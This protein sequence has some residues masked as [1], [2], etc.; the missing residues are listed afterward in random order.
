[1]TER[2]SATQL[3]SEFPLE[4]GLAYLNHAAVAPWPRR[5]SDAVA[6]FA[7]ENSHLGATHYPQWLTVEDQLRHNLA[8]LINAPSAQDI[9]LCKNTSEALSMVAAGLD[10]HEGDEIII[11]SQEFPSNRIVWESLVSRGVRIRV[12]DID[13]Q[14]VTPEGAIEDLITD[15][16]RLMSVSSVQYG[17][18]LRLDAAHLGALCDSHGILF[19]LD[20]IQS[21]GAEP[22]DVQAAGAHFAMADGHKWMLGPEGLAF[23]YVAPEWRESLK[24]YEYGWHMVAD[25][26]NFDRKDW[27]PAPDARRF[28]CGSPNLLAAHALEASTGLLLEVGLDQVRSLIDQRVSR[29]ASGLD[30]IKGIT[31]VTP[32]EP[33]RRLGIYTVQVDG[34]DNRHL[35]DRLAQQRVISASRGGGVRFSPHFYT[36]Y[37]AL[38]QALDT[39]ER[40]VRQG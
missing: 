36:P 33:Q 30:R 38:E 13:R 5:A 16:T 35:C 7:H 23:F 31:P 28:E 2:F 37:A 15:R 3:L 18:G 20:A 29:L 4:A 10:W 25:P 26:G 24:L 27:A 39:L 22:L 11:T 12:A 6:R 9:A 17:T 32:P 1:M 14:D 40:L 34:L 19:C 8:R 21:A